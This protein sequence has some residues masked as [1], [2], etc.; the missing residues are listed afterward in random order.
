MNEYHFSSILYC[1]MVVKMNLL[2]SSIFHKEMLQQ[3]YPFFV[4]FLW[5][6]LLRRSEYF[7]SNN[8]RLTILCTLNC[9]L[10]RSFLVTWNIW[11][12]EFILYNDSSTRKHVNKK[13]DMVFF[14]SLTCSPNF[15]LCQKRALQLQFDPPRTNNL[16]GWKINTQR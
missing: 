16:L 10:G 6:L 1:M 14:F 9:V 15:N 4:F 5:C 2:L 3:I 8:W 13:W 11:F 12:R 7:P